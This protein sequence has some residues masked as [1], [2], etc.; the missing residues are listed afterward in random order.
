MYG[1]EAGVLRGQQM[2]MPAHLVLPAHE[3]TPLAQSS[4]LPQCACGV[5]LCSSAFPASGSHLACRGEKALFCLAGMLEMYMDCDSDQ[6]RIYLWS[7]PQSSI[8]DAGRGGLCV[9][10]CQTLTPCFSSPPGR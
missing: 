6:H 5:W 4:P 2:D 10:L 8:Q 1:G 9:V 3:L 7:I